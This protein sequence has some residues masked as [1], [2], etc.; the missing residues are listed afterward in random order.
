VSEAYINANSEHV[1]VVNYT[2]HK[3]FDYTKSRDTK[4][5]GTGVASVLE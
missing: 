1:H 2:A 4:G 3:D 5:H